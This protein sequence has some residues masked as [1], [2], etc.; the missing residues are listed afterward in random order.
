M[1]F[2]L[3][4][5]FL[6]IQTH[7]QGRVDTSLDLLRLLEAALLAVTHGQGTFTLYEK[8]DPTKLHPTLG[9]SDVIVDL[10][11]GSL[12][13]CPTA[14]NGQGWICNDGEELV[15]LAD[16]YLFEELCNVQDK[17]RKGNRKP[18]TSPAVMINDHRVGWLG[19]Q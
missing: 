10:T 4:T 17:V 3:R 11:Y 9:D 12:S 16:Y 7:F 8:N 14:S 5:L 2:F 6:H 18:L 13:R 1:P 15:E 19:G